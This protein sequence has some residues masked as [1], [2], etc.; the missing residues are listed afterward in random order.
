[1]KF[2]TLTRTSILKRKLTLSSIR[3]ATPDTLSE[4]CGPGERRLVIGG[5][6]ITLKTN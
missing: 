2:P 6:L 4:G 1:M 5:K 3:L